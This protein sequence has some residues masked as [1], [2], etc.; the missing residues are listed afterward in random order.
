MYHLCNINSEVTF[1]KWTFDFCYMAKSSKSEKRIKAIAAR[2][3]QLRVDSGSS[4]YEN[5]AYDHDLPRV[6]YWRLEKGINFRMETLFK[7][8]DAHKMTLSEFFK[9]IE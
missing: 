3:K 1:M 2:I 5:F 7:V 4:S 6:Q 8:L 9:G